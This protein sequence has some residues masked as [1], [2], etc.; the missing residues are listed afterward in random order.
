MPARSTSAATASIT[1]SSRATGFS[2]K[3]GMP[4]RAAR[5]SIGAWAG[6]EV[7]TTSASTPAATSASGLSRV[8]AAS[9]AARYDAR[10][11]SSSTT[12]SR[13]TSSNPAR[14]RAWNA[15]I[16]PT[17]TTPTWIPRVIAASGYGKRLQRLVSS[18]SRRR[19][20]DQLRLEQMPHLLDLPALRQA[21]E[22][23]GRERGDLHGRLADRGERRRGV[24]GNV[25][26]VEAHDRHVVR[27]APSGLGDGVQHTECGEVVRG[28]DRGDARLALE[29]PAR[30]VVPAVV[31]EAPLLHELEVDRQAGAGERVAVTGESFVADAELARARDVPDPRVPEVDEMLGRDAA[32]KAVVHLDERDRPGVDVP[33]EADDREAVLD[34][35]GDPIGREDQAVD[36]RPVDL[37]RAQDA[38]VVLLAL[39]VARRR[40]EQHRV[41]VAQ[42]RLLDPVH[43][44]RVEG[45]RDVGEE[46]GD[47][48]RRL[49]DQA[50]SDRVRAV[51]ELLDGGLD[52]RARRRGDLPGPVRRSRDGGRRHTREPRDVVDRGPLTRRG[53]AHAESLTSRKRL[54]K[55]LSDEKTRAAARRRPRARRAAAGSPH[56]GRAHDGT[57]PRVRRDDRERLTDAFW[58][59]PG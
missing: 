18:A 6:V 35:A 1:S 2:Q 10:S 56:R 15:P 9:A 47:R 38:E 22:D 50:P 59:L 16:R 55:P 20:D 33:V 4:A 11:P 58:R 39:G 49:R 19:A 48:L 57:I 24:R 36:E 30:R 29:Q 41:P 12:V 43:E 34:E 21:D 44:R 26:V 32:A 54:R 31:G 7:A 27:H 23:L 28:E 8:S 40:A 52:R 13:S 25:Q 45:V 5:E 37:L 42:R 3:A 53:L 46:Q 51:A 17:P 14:V